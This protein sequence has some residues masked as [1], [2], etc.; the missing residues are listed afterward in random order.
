MPPKTDK[1]P[2]PLPPV[3]PCLDECLL[4]IQALRLKYDSNYTSASCTTQF[5]SPYVAA[6]LKK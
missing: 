2:N 6:A 3:P 4:K 5:R 1:K